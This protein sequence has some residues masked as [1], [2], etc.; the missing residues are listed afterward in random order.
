MS[1]VK[2]PAAVNGATCGLAALAALGSVLTAVAITVLSAGCQR[3][4]SPAPGSSAVASAPFAE[5]P[6][7]QRST[8]NAL[9]GRELYLRDCSACHG[10]DGD[11]RG[12][13]TRSLFPRPRD[14]RTSKFRLVSTV[15]GVPTSADLDAVTVR[16]IPGTSMPSFGQLDETPRGEL[17]GEVL[18]LRREGVRDS[19]VQRLR[20]EYGEDEFDEQELGSLLD[21]Q[22]TA[23]EPVAVPELGPATE[24][25]IQRG[26]EVFVKQNCPRCHGRDGTGDDGLYLADEEGYPTRPRNLVWEEFKGGPDPPSVYVRIRLGLLGTPMAANPNLSQ[27]ELVALVHYVRW[28]GREPKWQLTNHQRAKLVLDRGFLSP[29]HQQ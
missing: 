15:N 27:Q 6:A 19:V 24:A 7:R 17:I 16:G 20:D 2:F 18:R 10:A 13:A 3:P 22:L 4:A 5:S 21:L 28:L 25:M 29:G 11:G 8:D 23:G 1:H 14:F 9:T 12:A 26:Q